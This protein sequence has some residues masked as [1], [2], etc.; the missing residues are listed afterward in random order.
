MTVGWVCDVIIDR[1]NWIGFYFFFDNLGVF[2]SCDVISIHLCWVVEVL[3]YEGHL[4]TDFSRSIINSIS[5]YMLSCVHYTETEILFKLIPPW[6]CH[7]HW[8]VTWIMYKNM[9]TYFLLFLKIFSQTLCF[10]ISMWLSPTSAALF[11][12]IFFFRKN[13]QLWTEQ[14]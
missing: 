5:I 11:S 2:R 4:N 10:A 14:I 1:S 13:Y 6:L 8:A 7:S 3:R 12:S 9:S